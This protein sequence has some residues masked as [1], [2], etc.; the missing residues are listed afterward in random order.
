MAEAIQLDR[1][2]YIPFFDSTFGAEEGTYT[3][4]RIKYATSNDLT[5]NP[6]EETYSYIY[7]KNDTTE[8][9]GY[10]PTVEYDIAF[11]DEEAFK[12]M[13]DFADTFP[14]GDEAIVPFML[15]QP[16][17][18]GSAGTLPAIVWDEAMVSFSDKNMVDKKLNVVFK[19]NGDPTYGTVEAKENPTFTPNV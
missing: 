18:T 12:I 19:L 5:Y 2:K 11:K 1:S 7:S 4:V 15:V 9:T 10:A 3:W 13:S 14:T 17:L 16:D 8:I 6:T